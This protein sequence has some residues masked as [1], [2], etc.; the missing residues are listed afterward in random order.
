[1][2]II[3]ETTY[4]VPTWAMLRIEGFDESDSL[5]SDEEYKLAIFLENRL[6]PDKQ[7]GETEIW[8]F[9]EGGYYRNDV[10]NYYGDTHIARHY[11]LT[12]EKMLQD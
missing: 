3:K 1:M 8:T 10:D 6:E 2:K 7:K 9:E 11:I 12:P 4:R 5:T